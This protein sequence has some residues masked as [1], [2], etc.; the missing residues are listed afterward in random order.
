MAHPSVGRRRRWGLIGS[1]ASLGFF[2][3]LFLLPPYYMLVTSFKT[4]HEIQTMPGFPLIINEGITLSTTV[5]SSYTPRSSH[6]C[7]TP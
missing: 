6:S 4:P 3:V 5:A 7:K 1:Y 2:A